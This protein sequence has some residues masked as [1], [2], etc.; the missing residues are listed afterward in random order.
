[1]ADEEGGVI[2]ALRSERHHPEVALGIVQHGRDHGFGADIEAAL[3]GNEHDREDD[4]GERDD[5]AQA[6]VEEIAVGELPRHPHDLGFA[7]SVFGRQQ[8]AGIRSLCLH[9]LF[10]DP[11]R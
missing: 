3:H 2:E 4:A 5:E 9:R 1:M 6:V 10:L 8:G 7:L 11:Y